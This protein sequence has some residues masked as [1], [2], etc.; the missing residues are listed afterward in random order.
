[1]RIGMRIRVRTGM[2]HVDMVGVVVAQFNVWR[3]MMGV[4]VLVVVERIVAV[5][6][7]MCIAVRVRVRIG[8][9]IRM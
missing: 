4:L 6:V 8:M 3:V 5:P 2:R 9:R 7:R 1:M